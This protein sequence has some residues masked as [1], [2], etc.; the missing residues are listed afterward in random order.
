MGNKGMDISLEDQMLTKKLLL[1][2]FMKKLIN[3]RFY[4]SCWINLIFNPIIFAIIL[5]SIGAIKF[6]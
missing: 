4:I 3:K 2:N 6:K 1:M 5:W